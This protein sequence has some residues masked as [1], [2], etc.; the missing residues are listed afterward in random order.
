MGELPESD[1]LRREKEFLRVE[2][3]MK[4]IVYI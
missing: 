3:M 4:S 2:N 1:R